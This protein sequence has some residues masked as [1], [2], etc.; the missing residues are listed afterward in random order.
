MQG[1]N[2]AVV[3][4]GLSGMTAV[5][6]GAF[7]AH[8][9]KAVLDSEHLALIQTAAQYQ[10]WHTLALGLSALWPQGARRALCIA[11]WGFGLGIL[12]FSGSLYLLGLTNWPL[13]IVTPLGG[14]LLLVGWAA[15][16][17]AGWQAASQ[18]SHHGN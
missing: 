4:T 17:I 8:G 2:L 6:M 1:R 12:L 11:R 14:C 13:G 3:V 15:L 16:A 7:A 18:P 9:L 5:A 10:L